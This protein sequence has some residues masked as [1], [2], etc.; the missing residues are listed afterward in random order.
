MTPLT[1][2]QG[3]AACGH[4]LLMIGETF[5]DLGGTSRSGT[6]LWFPHATSELLRIGAN[7]ATIFLFVDY[8][9][10]SGSDK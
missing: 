9:K 1:R 8:I 7:I 6:Q 4:N 3:Q 2:S 5:A 10:T